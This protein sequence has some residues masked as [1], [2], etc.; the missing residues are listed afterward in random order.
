M[1]KVKLI[2]CGV[3]AALAMV[4]TSSADLSFSLDSSSGLFVLPHPTPPTT[5][6]QD[7]WYQVWWSAGSVAP[8]AGDVQLSTAQFSTVGL[9]ESMSGHWLIQQGGTPTVAG[10]PANSVTIQAGNGL[11]GGADISDG[12]LYA[13]VY[14]ETMA[15]GI[16]AAALYSE[17]QDTSA[18][19]T[20]TPPGAAPPA[21]NPVDQIDFA[22]A[23]TV[24]DGTHNEVIANVPEPGTMALFAL[25]IATIAWRR[26]K[27]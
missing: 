20:Y 6:P 13:I 10:F 9:Q 27:K 17:I 16:G 1:K 11:V 3:A 15:P 23:S 4:G 7:S 12:Y 19:Q 22:G 8:V 14:H 18:M 25:G 26:R 21:S 5:L 24:D 2:T